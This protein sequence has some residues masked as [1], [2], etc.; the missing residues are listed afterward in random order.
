MSKRVIFEET[1]EFCTCADPHFV[2][3]EVAS[4][5]GGEIITYK[6]G[7]YCTNCKKSRAPKN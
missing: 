3:D 1:D 5:Y 7:E 2:D 4:Q 6:I